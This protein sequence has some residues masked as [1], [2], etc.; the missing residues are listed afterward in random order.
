MKLWRNPIR[1]QPGEKGIVLDLLLVVSLLASTASQLRLGETSMGLGEI[2]LAVWLLI[3]IILA[4]LR[5]EE[6]LT[7]A[8]IRLLGFWSVF[9]LAMCFGTMA[10]Y[11]TGD[12][13]DPVWF[14]HDIVAYIFVAA[15]SAQYIGRIA[16]ATGD[17]DE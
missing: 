1:Y 12:V 16:K 17:R 5:L 6:P 4:T 7:P 10:G 3:N 13:H 15:L 11:A 8:A 14:R 2:G 9:A